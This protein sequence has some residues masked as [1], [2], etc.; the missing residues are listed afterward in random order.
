MIYI[1]MVLKEIYT[2]PVSGIIN[3]QTSFAEWCYGR[4]L[5]C[6]EG[7]GIQCQSNI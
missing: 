7:N 3:D 1:I 5:S 2:L 4:P 6:K